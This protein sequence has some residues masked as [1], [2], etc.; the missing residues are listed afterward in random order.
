[1]KR[2][3][4]KNKKSGLDFVVE[5]DG[6]LIMQPEYGKPARWLSGL[7][8]EREGIENATQT[9]EVD[10]PMG[11]VTEYFF[12]AEYT[13]TE[14]DMTGELAL[15]KA[16]QDALKAKITTVKG[17]KS[18]PKNAVNRNVLIDVLWDLLTDDDTDSI[19]E[20]LKHKLKS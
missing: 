9:K 4:I 14:E 11:K 18:Q 17:L 1:M 12:P 20:A 16:K 3:K 2:F 13:I 7:E 6:E 8:A 19:L 5:K 15:I 10:G